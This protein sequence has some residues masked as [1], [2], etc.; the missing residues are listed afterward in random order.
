MRGLAARLGLSGRTRRRDGRLEYD[1]QR[2]TALPGAQ[3]DDARREMSPSARGTHSSYTPFPDL[4]CVL[5]FEKHHS[6]S[7]A[8]QAASRRLASLAVWGAS[9]LAIS[10]RRSS[11]GNGPPNE[12]SPRPANLPGPIGSAAIVTFRA[13]RRSGY[14]IAS[15]VMERVSMSTSHASTPSLPPD[16]HHIVAPAVCDRLP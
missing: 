9:S 6:I 1:H 15:P 3:L 8:S 2:A 5:M 11:A 14:H 7:S 10:G 4:D 16:S 12:T 13:P